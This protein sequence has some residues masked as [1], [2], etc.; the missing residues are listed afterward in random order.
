MLQAT[1]SLGFHVDVLAYHPAMTTKCSCYIFT[2]SE[3]QLQPRRLYAAAA[4]FKSPSSYKTLLL[5]FPSLTYHG[6]YVVVPVVRRNLVTAV[7]DHSVLLLAQITAAIIA[8]KYVDTGTAFANRH[9]KS[10][11]R[12]KI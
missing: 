3:D 12:S 10:D 11:E 7:G 9:P 8:Q 6:R 2:Y 5:T 4:T 1:P